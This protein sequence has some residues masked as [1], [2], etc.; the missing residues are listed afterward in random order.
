MKILT[1]AGEVMFGVA[2]LAG[3]DKDARRQLTRAKRAKTVHVDENVVHLKVP[4]KCVL[5]AE[6]QTLLRHLANIR[7]H[8]KAYAPEEVE[9]DFEEVHHRI[10]RSHGFLLPVKFDLDTG[11]LTIDWP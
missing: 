10:A 7:K 6:L 8:G 2:E 9:R 3:Y 4:V 1:R 5:P 11:E